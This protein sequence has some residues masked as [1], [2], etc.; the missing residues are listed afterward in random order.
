MDEVSSTKNST[1]A[2]RVS[3]VKYEDDNRNLLYTN[4]LYV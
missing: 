2:L 1:R 3:Q 4:D